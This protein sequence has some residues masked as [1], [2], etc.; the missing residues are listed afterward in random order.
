MR[1]IYLTLY[2]TFFLSITDSPAQRAH[3][4]NWQYDPN[5]VETFIGAVV[6]VGS[7]FPPG[8]SFEGVVLL[9]RNDTE[10]IPVHLGPAWYLER[11]PV[12]IEDGDEI[13]VTGSRITYEDKPAIIA[14]RVKKGN[15]V[16][17]LKRQDGRPAWHGIGRRN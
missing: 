10:T 3:F 17:Q 4:Y 1:R 6:E 9:V 5:T 14:A 7:F 8:G 13:E 15:G 16:L 2:L 11:Q 12:R